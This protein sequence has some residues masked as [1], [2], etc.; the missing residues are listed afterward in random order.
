MKTNKLIFPVL[1][2]IPY[3]LQAQTGIGTTSP[4]TS[5]V[6]EIVAADKGM[7]IPRIGLNN[8]SGNADPLAAHVAGML[9]Y[10][11][12][13]SG[14]A[15]NQVTPGFYFNNG[16]KWVRVAD[17]SAADPTKDAWVDDPSNTQVKLGASS[18]GSS[19]GPGTE[20]VVEDGGK[21]GIGVTPPT[22]AL[23]VNGKLKVRN[24]A[25]QSTGTQRK[26]RQALIV[27][28]NSDGTITAV[29]KI[30]MIDVL[31][32]A[33]VLVKHTTINNWHGI[34]I[35]DN[36]ARL[37]F[38]GRTGNTGGP[39]FSF[40][41]IFKPGTGFYAL[42]A[43]N[44]TIEE[45]D[46]STLKVITSFGPNYNF[47]FTASDPAVTGGPNFYNVASTGSSAWVQGTFQSIP[48]N[49]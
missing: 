9:I 16:S 30:D 1:F 38:M 44:C 12:K 19:R 23:D 18:T 15:P 7:L 26:S 2:L 35:G 34:K 43:F 13:S 22:E 4:N 10:N 41:V 6:L 39:N 17:A 48:M 31:R 3:F 5:A 49:Y 42:S 36:A 37:T 45:V 40:E 8:G 14:T 47:T 32:G 11:T 46:A 27:D 20:F 24:I 25:T 28:T 21:V 29:S 33:G